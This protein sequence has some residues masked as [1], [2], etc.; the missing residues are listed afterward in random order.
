MQELKNERFIANLAYKG[1]VIREVFI[2][3]CQKTGF[4]PNIIKE[5]DDNYSIIILVAAGLGITIT[6]EG[7]E[8]LNNTEVKYIPIHD[9][10]AFLDMAIVWREDN[11]SILIRNVLKTI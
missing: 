5:V 9:S 2:A 1:S 6:L 4:N 7:L 8:S 10:E 11:P 3:A